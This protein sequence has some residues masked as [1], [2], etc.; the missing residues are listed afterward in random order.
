M[1]VM[2]LK[3]WVIFSSNIYKNT[4]LQEIFLDH[5]DEVPIYSETITHYALNLRLQQE[6]GILF[7]T[8]MF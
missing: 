4:G 5:I 2:S 1:S 7:S 6:K 8:T 3:G